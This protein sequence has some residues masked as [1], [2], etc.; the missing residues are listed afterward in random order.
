[1]VNAVGLI[2]TFAPE[3]QSFPSSHCSFFYK[4]EAETNDSQMN[5]AERTPSYVEM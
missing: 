2:A 3:E 4:I 1:M 5:L